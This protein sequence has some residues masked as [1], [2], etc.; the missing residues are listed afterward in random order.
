MLIC[1]FD[2]WGSSQ[3]SV[4]AMNATRLLLLLWSST[5][6]SI[7]LILYLQQLEALDEAEGKPLDET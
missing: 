2:M 7:S 5:S 4:M 3:V 1:A 6:A